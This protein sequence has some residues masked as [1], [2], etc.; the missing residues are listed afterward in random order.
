MLVCVSR[1]DLE[2]AWIRSSRYPCGQLYKSSPYLPFFRSFSC[3]KCTAAEAAPLIP[4]MRHLHKSLQPCSKQRS[5]TPGLTMQMERREL[6]HLLKNSQSST[7][8]G[9]PHVS[10]LLVRCPRIPR[11]IL[12]Q[13]RNLGKSTK[14]CSLT[15]TMHKASQGIEHFDTR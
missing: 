12:D 10:R 2:L 8:L 3:I 7:R 11:K 13:T 14:H 6:V 9:K 1:R 5:T 4:L 15:C